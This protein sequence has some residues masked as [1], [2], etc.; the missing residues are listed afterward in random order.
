MKD[1]KDKKKKWDLEERTSKFGEAVILFCKKV[2][3]SDYYT[4]SYTV[5]KS[6][7]ECRCKL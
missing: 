1:E 7:S 2:P 5:S 3:L 4:F 6:R